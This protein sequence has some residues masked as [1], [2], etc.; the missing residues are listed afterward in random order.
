MLDALRDAQRRDGRNKHPSA[1]KTA[2]YHTPRGNLRDEVFEGDI[3]RAAPYELSGYDYC[4]QWRDVKGLPV[5]FRNPS[6]EVLHPE[7]VPVYG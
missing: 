5:T 2:S 1:V 4:S 7:D 3:L 6:G